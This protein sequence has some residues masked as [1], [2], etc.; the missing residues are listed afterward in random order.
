[1]FQS[2]SSPDGEIPCKYYLRFMLCF[3]LSA[4]QMEK[5]RWKSTRGVAAAKAEQVNQAENIR[6]IWCLAW[7]A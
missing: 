2:I 5:L 7:A 3:S 4:L 1:M 6:N